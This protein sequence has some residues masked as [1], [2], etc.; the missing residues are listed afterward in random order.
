MFAAHAAIKS[1]SARPWSFF[2]LQQEHPTSIGTL[3]RRLP[4]GA[5]SADAGDIAVR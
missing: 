4:I 1:A 2:R 5:K 3:D